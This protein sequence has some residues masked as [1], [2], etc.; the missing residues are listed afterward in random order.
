MEALTLASAQ[1][2]KGA[3]AS[4]FQ[5]FPVTVPVPLPAPVAKNCSPTVL[6]AAPIVAR[7]LAYLLDNVPLYFGRLKSLTSDPDRP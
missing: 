6:L 4:L 7:E 5:K 3:A 2:F 1:P